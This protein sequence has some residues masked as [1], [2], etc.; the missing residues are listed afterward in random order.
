MH[1]ED[2]MR[3]ERGE[4]RKVKGRGIRGG[5]HSGDRSDNSAIGI[6]VGQHS[7]SRAG[8]RGKVFCSASLLLTPM[9]SLSTYQKEAPTLLDVGAICRLKELSAAK[10]LSTQLIEG[11]PIVI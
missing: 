7:T 4:K 5:Y 11:Y 1:T 10:D 3:V 9:H 2:N 8:K 6:K